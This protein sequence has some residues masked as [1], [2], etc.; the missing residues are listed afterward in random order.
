MI[1]K[2]CCDMLKRNAA[3]FSFL[4]S[5]MDNLIITGIWIAAYY[6]RFYSGVFSFKKRVPFTDHLMLTIPIVGLCYLACFWSGL[7]NPKR[8]Q[9]LF[10]QVI[11]LLKAT[12]LSGLLVLAFLYYIRSNPYS[13]I[14]LIVFIA[15]LF[16]GLCLS[17][18]VVMTGLRYLRKK[19][20]N[21]R[22]YAVI[23]TGTR[24]QQIVRDLK[25]MEWTGLQCS[26]FVDDNPEQDDTQLLG[27]PVCAPIEKIIDQVKT[28]EIDEVYVALNGNR[29]AKL[30]AILEALQSF[31]ITI[32]LLPDWGGLVSVS[33]PTVVSIGEQ[34]LFSAGDSPLVG[35]NIVIKEVF[36]RTMALLLILLLS[37]PMLVIALLIKL[38]SRG[39]VFYQQARIGMDQKEFNI[40]KFRT[41]KTDAEKGNGPQWAQSED[42]RCTRI[43][44]FL[45]K[46]SLD[47]LPQLFNVLK[48]DMSLVG[49]RPE[50]PFFVRKFSENHRR[51]MLR[52]KVKSGMTGWAQIHGLRGNTSLRKRLAYDLY[53]VKNWSFMLDIWI[54]LRTPLHVLKGENAY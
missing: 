38:T 25:R 34:L 36:D 26:F 27:V 35:I 45:R 18:L 7:Y 9:T 13:R 32:R 3:F 10:R 28:R 1:W 24:A 4:R 48:G 20:Y 50:R 41:M 33:T 5:L 37:V 54:L 31:G 40:L 16:P 12:F 42:S 46:T 30:N 11:E 39:P 17:H 23:G 19:G 53:Y 2:G 21:Q 15:T 49:P 47:E 22:Y 8:M 14:A 6:I 52:H 29:P 51:Y 43:G 44:C